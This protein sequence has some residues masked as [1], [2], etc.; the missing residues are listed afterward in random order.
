M[1]GYDP[2]HEHRTGGM[3]QAYKVLGQSGLYSGTGNPGSINAL[4]GGRDPNNRHDPNTAMEGPWM[5]QHSH[6][7]QGAYFPHT[8]VHS[9]AHEFSNHRVHRPQHVGLDDGT[10][11]T[12]HPNP[13][14]LHGQGST[15][16]GA[17]K[18]IA[19]AARREA[20]YGR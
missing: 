18:G 9:S 8:A 11:M 13:R 17:H 5:Q 1:P 19:L 3:P 4:P 16:R 7:G 2:H 20:R 15:P 6:Y 14:S 10:Y 12:M